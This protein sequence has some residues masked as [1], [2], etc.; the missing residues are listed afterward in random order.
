MDGLLIDINAW[1]GQE[2]GDNGLK[3]FGAGQMKGRAAKELVIFPVDIE[4]GIVPENLLHLVNFAT[5][6]SKKVFSI[7]LAACVEGELRN[8]RRRIVNGGGCWFT[9]E[10]SLVSVATR[11]GPA[12]P[13]L[14]LT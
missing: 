1:M 6:A 9:S 4:G 3:S 11:A 13:G 10:V 12:R 8:R 5:T 7:R 2:D 14:C